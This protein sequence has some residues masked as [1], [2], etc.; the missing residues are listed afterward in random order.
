MVKEY[1][2]RAIAIKKVYE[3][4]MKAIEIA[5]LLSI[6]PQKVNYWIHHPITYK[7]KRREKLTK[8]E[9][10]F[11]IKWA[12][13]KPINI[14]S[15]K[16]IQKR[17][18]RLSKYQ[19]EN[20]LQKK[21][22][23]S[24]INKILNKFISKP[25]KI[26]KVF[27][28][29]E[30][31][32]KKRYEFLEFMKKKKIT[33]SDIFFTDESIFNLSSLNGNCKIRI[34]KKMQKNLKCGNEK[35]INLIARP[36]HKKVNGIMISGGICKKGLSHLIFHSGNV[37]TFSYKQVLDFY[38]ED[39]NDFGVKFFQQDGARVHSSKSVEG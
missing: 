13:N 37:N 8:N 5:R 3:A 6:S 17:F 22:S 28:L 36:V 29:T 4:G 1:Q 2:E 27:L 18:N 20:K 30:T 26:R 12:K 25:K 35:A 38:K 33:P 21:V 16:R 14:A 10:N 11:I 24:T 34:S 19:K 9:R 23:I 7:K 15:A 32:K 39:I 31:Q